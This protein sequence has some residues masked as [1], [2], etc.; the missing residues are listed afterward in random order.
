EPR[1]E[2]QKIVNHYVKNETEIELMVKWAG[3]SELAPVDERH[4]QQECPHVLDRYWKSLGTR[5]KATGVNLFHVFRIL[6]W[7]IKHTE[8]QFKVQWVG[9][10][11]EESTWELAWR[12]KAFAEEMHTR[13]LE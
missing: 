13:Y 6:Q 7:R 10:P 8:L 5:E 3:Y 11:L 9:Y 4:F 12:V 1:F 2:V